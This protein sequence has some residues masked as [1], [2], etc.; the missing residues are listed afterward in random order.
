MSESMKLWDYKQT[1]FFNEF[2]AVKVYGADGIVDK[3]VDLSVKQDGYPL[4][5]IGMKDNDGEDLFQ[6]DTV[7]VTINTEFGRVEVDGVIRSQ[8]L[9]CTGVDLI[10]GEKIELDGFYLD[11]LFVAEVH[12][13]GSIF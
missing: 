6:G 12:R 3:T 9:M 1:Y 10:K 2:P 4:F 11:D 8:G 5:P 7:S 13:T